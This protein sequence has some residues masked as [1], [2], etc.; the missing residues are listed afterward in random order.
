MPLGIAAA[1]TADG[2]YSGRLLEFSFGGQ[3]YEATYRSFQEISQ[4]AE[5]DANGGGD[6]RK[7]TVLDVLDEMVN[8]TVVDK[9]PAHAAFD[10]FEVGETGALVWKPV[11]TLTTAKTHTTTAR[12][13]KRTRTFERATITVFDVEMRITADIVTTTQA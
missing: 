9:S 10:A 8:I 4:A 6:T 3:Q 11:G 12:V 1:K 7:L 5:I 2:R 13:N